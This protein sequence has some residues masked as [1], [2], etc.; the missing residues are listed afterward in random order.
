MEFI[1]NFGTERGWVMKKASDVLRGLK[2]LLAGYIT[3]QVG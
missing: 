1:N 2:R 3:P